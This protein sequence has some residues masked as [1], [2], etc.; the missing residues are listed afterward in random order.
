MAR[1]YSGCQRLS[2]QFVFRAACSAGTSDNSP[3]FQRRGGWK[4]GTVPKGR[5]N[6]EHNFVQPFLWN[7]FA[8]GSFP[9]L[10]RRAILER[11][12]GTESPTSFATSVSGLNRVFK[13]SQPDKIFGRW[14][15]AHL[16]FF[17]RRNFPAQRPSRPGQS[18]G[19]VLVRGRAA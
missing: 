6:N 2:N 4:I 14:R 13:I 1:L 11:P 17:R 8:V 5:L 9:A 12:C 16:P 18:S 3:A 10:K 19:G 7:S 15:I